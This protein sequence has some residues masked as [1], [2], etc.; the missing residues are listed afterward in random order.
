MNNMTFT[1]DDIRELL[2]TVQRD[3]QTQQSSAQRNI[4]INMGDIIE[5]CDQLTNRVGNSNL[6]NGTIQTILNFTERT[7][8]S[9]TS[10]EQLEFH[11]NDINAILNQL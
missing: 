5:H 3:I 8:T 1:I 2:Q 4:E 10:L 6:P 9:Q 7:W 11:L